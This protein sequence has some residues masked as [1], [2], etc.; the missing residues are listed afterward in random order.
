[1]SDNYKPLFERQPVF[2]AVALAIAV[3]P[4]PIPSCNLRLAFFG[5]RIRHSPV[6]TTINLV[7]IR[8]GLFALSWVAL[9]SMIV[10]GIP[11]ALERLRGRDWAI[12]MG[13]RHDVRQ[14]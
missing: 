5:C 10:R 2:Y 4:S 9:G 8:A 12:V 6:H 14:R 1:M 7:P 11:R 3:A 13:N